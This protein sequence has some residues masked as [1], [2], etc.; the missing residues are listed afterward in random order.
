MSDNIT[1]RRVQESDLAEMQKLFVDTIITVCVND[2]NSDQITAW[3]SSVKNT[4]RWL[5]KMKLQY[6]LVAIIED[7]IVGY[8]SLENGSYFDILYVHKDFQRNGI[9]QKLLIEIE[10]KAKAESVVTID[11]DVSITAR[12]FF[13]RNGYITQKT[14]TNIIDGVKIITYRMTKQL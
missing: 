1:I 13:E 7:R 6:F 4:D 8:A 9:A 3:A 5:S 2:Y 11:S 12:P 10:N 14:N